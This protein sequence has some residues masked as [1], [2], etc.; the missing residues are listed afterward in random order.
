MN[1]Q[2]TSHATRRGFL[3]GVVACVCGAIAFAVPAVTG[4]L[5]FL[6]PLQQKSRSGTLMRLA[7]LDV[8]PEDGTPKKFPII[9]DQTDAWTHFPAE[10][11]GAVFLRRAGGKALAFQVVCPHA[12]CA[13]NFEPSSAGG[14]FFCPCHAASFDLSGK[15]SDATSPSPRDMDSLAV[16]IRNQNEVWVK[17][18]N[19]AVGTARKVAQG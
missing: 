8:L 11:I 10:P 7:S 15:R 14:K 3:G 1:E 13:I 2:T 6:N 12:G 4:F 16:E 5:A 19:F 9:A 17:F 18:E